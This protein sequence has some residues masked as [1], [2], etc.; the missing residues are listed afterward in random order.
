M[1]REIAN[2]R[3]LWPSCPTKGGWEGDTGSLKTETK[4]QTCR[5]LAFPHAYHH[6]TKGLFIVVPLTQYI[7][8]SYQ[9]KQLQDSLNDKKQF[10]ETKSTSELDSDIAVL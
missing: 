8:F 6:V 2:F 10:E 4:S 7:V 5:T 9:E 3:S 1:G